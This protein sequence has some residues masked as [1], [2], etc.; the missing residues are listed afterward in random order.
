MPSHDE[1]ERRAYE[2]YEQRGCEDGHD[3]DDWLLAEAQL[4]RAEALAQPPA[5]TDMV[6]ITPR[7]TRG[8]RAQRPAAP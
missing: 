5:I 8:E 2:L 1:V 7:R 4:R 3:R 6:A